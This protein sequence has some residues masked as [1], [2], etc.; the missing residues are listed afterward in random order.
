MI[1][2]KTFLEEGMRP[3]TPAEWDKP[4]S[5]TDEPRLTILKRL[6]Q[7]KADIVTVDNDTIKLADDERNYGSIKDFEDN[8]G[9]AFTLYKTN[10]DMI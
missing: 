8:P 9:K 5:Q 3:L 2:F 10:G 4:N 7:Q 6:I 1:Q